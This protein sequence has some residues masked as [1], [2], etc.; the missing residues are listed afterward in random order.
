LHAAITKLGCDKRRWE[1]EKIGEKNGSNHTNKKEMSERPRRGGRT[2]RAKNL[3]NEAKASA[4]AESHCTV[5]RQRRIQVGESCLPMT[6]LRNM[7][8][9]FGTVAHRPEEKAAFRPYTRRGGQE[10]E[11]DHRTKLGLHATVQETL[12]GLSEN[13]WPFDE[14]LPGN[15]YVRTLMRK[16]AWEK[17]SVIARVQDHYFKPS[18]VDLSQPLRTDF[19]ETCL[20]GHDIDLLV[21][22]NLSHFRRFTY[23]LTRAPSAADTK[24]LLSLIHKRFEDKVTVKT[25]RGKRGPRGSSQ[26]KEERR[27][28]VYAI[29][30][31]TALGQG[32]HWV[33]ALFY[34]L[35]KRCEYFDSLGNGPNKLVNKALQAVKKELATLFG[36]RPQAW[37]Q[38]VSRRQHQKGSTQCGLYVFWYFMQRIKEHRSPEDLSQRA[39]HDSVLRALRQVYFSPAPRTVLKLMD[40]RQKEL[41]KVIATADKGQK[42]KKKGLRLKNQV[43]DLTSS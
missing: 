15:P 22:Q 17:E 2:V 28:Q 13:L 5:R 42:K 39:V 38:T 11:H 14:L 9:N 19:S 1:P 16:H 21:R 6:I 31:N 43:V 34:P 3:E 25:G 10:H 29:V 33:C 37:K 26:R 20:S 23:L 35:E 32:S 7:L 30:W 36:F 4:N 40:A 41:A 27:Y 24:Q 12:G 8:R 18:L